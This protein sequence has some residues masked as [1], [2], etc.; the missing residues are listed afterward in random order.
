[1]CFYNDPDFYATVISTEVKE[2][3]YSRVPV[4]CCE[5]GEIMP[6]GSKMHCVTMQEHKECQNDDHEDNPDCKHDF[7]ESYSCHWCDL[8][9]KMLI[10]I[11][12]LEEEEGCP[13]GARRPL[14]EG[15]YESLVEHGERDKYAE[16]ALAMFPELSGHRILRWYEKPDDDE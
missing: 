6:L 12:L 8:C 15:L 3:P 5:C 13:K 16:A 7:G 1:M 2:V 10:A 11:E 9:E 4:R 14:H